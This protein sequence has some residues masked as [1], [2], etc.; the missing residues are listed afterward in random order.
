MLSVGRPLGAGL[1]N[2]E[3]YH[4]VGQY[5]HVQ[6]KESQGGLGALISNQIRG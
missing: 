6:V 2:T 1:R 3:Q 4:C 5:P